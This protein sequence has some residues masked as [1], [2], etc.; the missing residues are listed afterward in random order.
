MED[1]KAKIAQLLED[2]YILIGGALSPEETEN[3][4]Q[5]VNFAREQGLGRG[6]ERCR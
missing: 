6:I 1:Q 2:G 5:R 3:I 4:R